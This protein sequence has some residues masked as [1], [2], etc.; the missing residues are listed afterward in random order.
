M[1]KRKFLIDF[2]LNHIY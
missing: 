1:I 2:N